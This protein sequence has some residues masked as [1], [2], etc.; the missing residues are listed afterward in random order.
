MTD[1]HRMPPDERADLEAIIRDGHR[2]NARPDMLRLLRALPWASDSE[3]LGFW[4]G[5]PVD[6]QVWLAG[7][8]AT[9]EAA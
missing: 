3:K 2:L 1:H 4:Q 7:E 6:L 8:A 9:G 5:L